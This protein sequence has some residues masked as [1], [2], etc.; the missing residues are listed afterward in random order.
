MNPNNQNMNNSMNY[1]MQMNQ[2][3]FMNQM[4]QMNPMYKMNPM[5]QMNPMNQMNPMYQM[6]PMN[7]M[8]QIN[9]MNQMNHNNIPNI[10]QNNMDQNQP[11]N[12]SKEILINFNS[13][14]GIMDQIKTIIFKH[15][16][17]N[18]TYIANISIY[19]RKSDL[20][21]LIKQYVKSNFIL[22]Y[23]DDILEN[24][25][26][27]IDDIL[28]GAIIEIYDKISD[29]NHINNPYYY[30]LLE[31]NDNFPKKNYIFNCSK[32]KRLYFNFPSN[33]SI[34]QMIKVMKFEINSKN[35]ISIMYNNQKLEDNDT[36]KLSDKISDNAILYL[37]IFSSVQSG[38][39]PRKEI[40][41]II[42][43]K[44][45]NIVKTID[46]TRFNSINT[47][48]YSIE[49][50]INSKIKKLS[51]EDKEINLNEEKSIASLGINDDF[52]CTVEI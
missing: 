35:G 17:T 46:V 28:D 39:P 9:Q 52:I 14:Y 22:I 16:S 15:R 45:K 21:W 42:L 7:P 13:L 2:M 10:M 11:Q 34:S 48:V 23:T 30:Y 8:N 20:Y 38:F 4:N 41:V 51:I 24:D 18:T 19:F 33:I 25:E 49:N 31:K 47:L 26:S 29:G 32:G 6:N 1:Q 3:N 36:T 50:K 5:T 12:Q 40:K 44:D 27:N 43:V 37:N